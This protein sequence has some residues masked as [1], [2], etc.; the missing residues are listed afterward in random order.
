M[1]F[2]WRRA[3]VGLVGAGLIL[4][5]ASHTHA[6]TAV[7]RLGELELSVLGV[8]AGVEPLEPV[9]PKNTASG[10]KIVVRGGGVALAAELAR[11]LGSDFRVEACASPAPVCR[12]P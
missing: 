10:V 12:R 6:Q 7:H 11:L 9:V 3:W 2:E 5:G 8:S 1:A 4:A